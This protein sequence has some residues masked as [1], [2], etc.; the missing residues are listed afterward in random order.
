MARPRQSAARGPV[1]TAWPDFNRFCWLRY[2]T[3]RTWPDCE[4]EP[5]SSS[6]WF[7][8][9]LGD[10]MNATGLDRL[11]AGP[12]PWGEFQASARSF[13]RD[14]AARRFT[15]RRLRKAVDAY[16]RGIARLVTGPSPAPKCVR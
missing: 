1:P 15:R 7:D 3:G 4:P 11:T 2:G 6:Y 14:R 12:L 10:S 5:I 8:H 9:D 16:H 13:F